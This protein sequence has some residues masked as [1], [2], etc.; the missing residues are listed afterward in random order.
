MQVGWEDAGLYECQAGRS[1]EQV[2]RPST[3]RPRL[4]L[5]I[6]EFSNA[7][8]AQDLLENYEESL[9]PLKVKQQLY[10]VNS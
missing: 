4:R 8:Q 2:T 9:V 7:E 6:V 10:A 3:H 5:E 1:R